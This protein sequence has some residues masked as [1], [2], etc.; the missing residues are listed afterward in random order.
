MPE[1]QMVNTMA[2]RFLNKFTSIVTTPEMF[3]TEVTTLIRTFFSLAKSIATRLPVGNDLLLNQK[4]KMMLKEGTQ[5]S[6]RQTSVATSTCL[7]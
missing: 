1:K 5:T 3:V 6:A 2:L 7:D 4:R